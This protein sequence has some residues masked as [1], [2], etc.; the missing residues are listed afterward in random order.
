MSEPEVPHLTDEE[1]NE[2]VIRDLDDPEAWGEPVVVGPS[3]G[4][5]PVRDAMRL[6][7]GGN[8]DDRGV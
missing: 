6:K 4:A 1:I 3:K 7:V 8:R 2:L 5:R